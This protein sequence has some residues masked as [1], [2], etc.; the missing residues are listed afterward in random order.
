MES[1][2]PGSRN[3]VVPEETIRPGVRVLRAIVVVDVVES[4]RLMQANETDIIDRWRRFVADVR[5]DL[6]PRCGGRLVKSLGDG[7][8]LEFNDGSHALAAARALIRRVEPMNHGRSQGERIELRVGLHLAEIIV[9]DLDIYGQGVNLA[10]RLAG[11]AGPG[12]MAMSEVFRAAIEGTDPLEDLVDL[13]LCYLKHLDQPIR[14]F[15]VGSAS[16]WRPRHRA[17]LQVPAAASSDGPSQEPPREETLGVQAT[18]AVL[19]FEPASAAGDD[20][21]VADLVSDALVARLAVSRELRVIS[22]WSTRQVERHPAQGALAWSRLQ[23]HYL[24][25]GQVRRVGARMI[26]GAELVETVG[27]S[28]LW[29]G[30]RH[31]VLSDVLN[32]EDEFSLG[33]A[34][35]IAAVIAEDQLRRV[36]TS[37]LPTLDGNQLQLSAS[38]LMHLED[39]TGFE[40]AHTMLDHLIDRY[41]REPGPR[42]WSAMWYVLHVTRGFVREP[43]RIADRALDHVNRALDND[44]GCALALAMAGFVQCHLRRDLDA[45]EFALSQAVVLNPNE[46]WAW[47]F[48]SVVASHRGRGD[49]AWAW[50]TR[51]SALSPLDPLRHYFDGLRSNAAL[52]AERWQDAV[53]LATRSL[54]VNGRHLPTLRG[55]AIAQVSL[56]QLAQARD[57]G[58]RI[59]VVDPSFNLKSYLAAAPP[60]GK[61]T[62]RRYVDL[63]RQAGL[64]MQGD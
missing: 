44:P 58:Q 63:L 54:A 12:E 32:P 16:S 36:R 28:V 40:R 30:R 34:A 22:R 38:T 59:L 52:V 64:P 39:V 51:A 2:D 26:A 5:A 13:G 46:K 20:V 56:G 15:R 61:E 7:L 53:R 35:E 33:L 57:T 21:V 60:D 42:A 29:A 55:L 6:L 4:V 45:A 43:E 25:R 3:K 11:L 49:E 37:A 9:D 23:A 41:P 48:R 47:L 10:A 14:A 24:V 27:D 19:S 50:A 1:D 8:L 31:F 62:R 17:A 18:V